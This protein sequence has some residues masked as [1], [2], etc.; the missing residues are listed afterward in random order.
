MTRPS[1]L[2]IVAL[3][4]FSMDA[5]NIKK[6]LENSVIEQVVPVPKYFLLT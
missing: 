3:V 2:Y 4:S 5:T 6:T 1:I